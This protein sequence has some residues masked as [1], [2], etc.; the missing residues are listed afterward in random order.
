MCTVV[1]YVGN[2]YSRA[3]ILES[4]SR[5]EYRGYDSAG[6]ACLTSADNRLVYRKS[7][8]SVADLARQCDNNPIDGYMGIGHTRW[9]THGIPSEVNAHP[10]FD[11]Q[12]K[13]SLVH[14]GIIEN[15]HVLKQQLLS[16]GHV[17]LSQ[18]D[19]EV[20]VHLFEVLFS[21]TQD[22]KAAIISLVDKLQGAYSLLFLLE[23]YPDALIAVRKKSPLCIGIG[24]QEM[25]VASDVTAFAGRAEK[26]VFLPDESFAFVGKNSIELYDFSGKKLQPVAEDIDAMW[27]YQG[28]QGYEHFML[29]EIYEQKKVLHSTIDFLRS[30]NV[31]MWDHVGFTNEYIASIDHITFIGCGS[32]WNAAAIARYVFE[33][34]CLIPASVILAS[35]FRHQSLFVNQKN[36][37]CF[38]SQSGETADTLEALRLVNESSQITMAVTNVASSSM[39]REAQG[40]LLTQAQQEIS[41]AST[42]AFSAQIGLLY[43]L[44]HR[45]AVTK[46]ILPLDA[47]NTAFN[48]VML[49][50]EIL[51]G[52]IEKYASK[53]VR[54]LA[55]KYAH[56]KQFIFIGRHSS[57]SF[58][59][60]AAL[61][62]KELSYIFVDCY[63]AGELKHGALALVDETI[64]VVVF[65]SL[66]VPVYRKLIANAQEVKARS[67]H[68]VVFAFEGQ[69][70]LIDLAD[71]VFIFPHVHPLLASLAYCGVMQFFVYHIAKCLNRPI[72]KPRNLA[73]SVTVE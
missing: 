41:V 6:L 30:I 62:L 27:I 11:C 33:K 18:T 50:A 49:A 8:G 32:S 24:T 66:D 58:A 9:S 72:D 36:L 45:I 37:Y 26:V 44:A 53:I 73:K 59:L 71:T 52:S 39:V 16:E 34:V 55:P 20:A 13:I 68:L 63:P 40:F 2:E 69:Q 65:S 51:E 54:E 15:Y 46:G 12:K 5:L 19:S 47:M 60:E 61:K 64:P 28:K 1:G 48:D 38:I 25:F 21:D 17:F 10:H 4:L 3:F 31:R 67:G 57:Y 35:E 42:K 23:A 29:K 43:L 70:E 56:Y 14:N 7:Q 22:V